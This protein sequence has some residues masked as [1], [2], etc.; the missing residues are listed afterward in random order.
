MDLI[1]LILKYVITNFCNKIIATIFT[2]KNTFLQDKQGSEDRA[3]AIT[4]KSSTSNLKALRVILEEEE[5]NS[6]A[7]CF[8]Q[9]SGDLTKPQIAKRMQDIAAM[10]EINA[11]KHLDLMAK[12]LQD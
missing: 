1:L 5:Q 9:V 4:G 6:L 12:L 3:V 2:K 11:T 10:R 8:S 7:P